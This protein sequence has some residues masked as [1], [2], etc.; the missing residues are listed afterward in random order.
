MLASLSALLLVAASPLQSDHYA[1]QD[2]GQS[3]QLPDI[4]PFAIARLPGFGFAMKDRFGE[5]YYVRVSDDCLSKREI[6]SGQGR[7]YAV[8]VSPVGRVDRSAWIARCPVLDV[9]KGTPR[10]AS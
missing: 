8:R 6:R 3:F 5:I 1:S 2:G 9:Y 7:P 10:P 4:R